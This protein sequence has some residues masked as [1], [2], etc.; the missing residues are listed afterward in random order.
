M[1]ASTFV[2]ANPPR[3]SI[4]FGTST[5]TTVSWDTCFNLLQGHSTSKSSGQ[6][7]WGNSIV[8]RSSENELQP[9]VVCAFRC[10]FVQHFGSFELFCEAIPDVPQNW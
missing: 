2:L 10:C 4:H 1:L 6:H 7:G 5:L 9:E 8:V 3:D